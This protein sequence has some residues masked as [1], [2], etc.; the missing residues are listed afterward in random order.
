MYRPQNQNK[1]PTINSRWQPYPRQWIAGVWNTYL[2]LHDRTVT[3]GPLWEIVLIYDTA[4]EIELRYKTDGINNLYNQIITLYLCIPFTMSLN[5][6]FTYQLRR[7]FT[8]KQ[9]LK[10]FWTGHDYFIFIIIFF[11]AFF[12]KDCNPT[13]KLV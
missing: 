7:K 6:L 9:I 8:C 1:A 10:I 4:A 13:F 11:A 12:Q 2:L 3:E 5:S